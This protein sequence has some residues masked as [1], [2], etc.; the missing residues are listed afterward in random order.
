M[1]QRENGTLAR[2]NTGGLS[3]QGLRAMNSGGEST[4]FNYTTIL[5][6]LSVARGRGLKR[7][8]GKKRGRA[9]PAEVITRTLSAK[10]PKAQCR[11][12]L[13]PLGFPF[14]EQKGKEIEANMGHAM[15]RRGGI[16]SRSPQAPSSE[17]G[18]REV[19]S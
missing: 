8:D 3:G 15:R 1:K 2:R 17:T 5:P 12:S 7:I 13:S 4:T 6:G 19:E 11:D 16:L 18:R 10:N 14:Q 9:M